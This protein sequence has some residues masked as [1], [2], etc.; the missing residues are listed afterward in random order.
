MKWEEYY[1]KN[2]V[3]S[4][5]IWPD[6]NIVRQI[7]RLN[8][9]KSAPILDL[10]CGEG[11]NTRA[12]VELGFS[13]VICADQSETALS[14]VNKLYKVPSDKLICGQIPD[15]LDTF[16]KDH[17][18]VIL[19]WGLM[20]YIQEPLTTLLAIRK[21]LRVD[22]KIIMSFNAIDEKR[23]TVDTVKKYYNKEEVLILMEKAEFKVIDFGKQTTENYMNNS[24]ESY[25]W[26]V[27]EKPS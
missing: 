4:P 13:N 20:H 11:R 26:L 24:S 2:R 19:C 27:A 1:Q 7:N 8:I 22:G 5:L 21:H 3:Q 12:L 18:L 16:Q 25:Y 9:E 6:V 14:L 17:F 10:A 23:P 15:L